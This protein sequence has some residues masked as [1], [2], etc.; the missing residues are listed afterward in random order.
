MTGT[1]HPSTIRKTIPGCVQVQRGGEGLQHLQNRPKKPASKICD[2]GH[3]L[4]LLASP[5]VTQSPVGALVDHVR[6][7]TGR[8]SHGF[9]AVR[10]V[11]RRGADSQNSRL[12]P[13]GCLERSDFHVSPSRARHPVT[14]ICLKLLAG[15]LGGRGGTLF[16]QAIRLARKSP[17]CQPWPCAIGRESRSVQFRSSTY[18]IWPTN[19]DSAARASSP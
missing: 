8:T 16:P 15:S 9:K 2:M 18:P 10:A 1:R 7:T 14:L 13:S 12:D 3:S 4:F 5:F 11:G 19:P 6:A 17:A